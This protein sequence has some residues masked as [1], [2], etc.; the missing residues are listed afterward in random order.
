M[1]PSGDTQDATKKQFGDLNL[2]IIGLGTQYPPYLLDPSDLDTLCKRHYPETPAYVPN[3]SL[4]PPNTDNNRTA[5]PK[6]V[7]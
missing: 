3:L 7:Q 5:W 2:S 1:S 6:S 4:C